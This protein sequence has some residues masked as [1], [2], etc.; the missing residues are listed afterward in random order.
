MEMLDREEETYVLVEYAFEYTAKDGRLVSIKPN[1]RYVLLRRTNDHWWHVRKGKGTRPFYIPAK[2][3]KELAPMAQAMPPSAEL[4]PTSMPK[5]ARLGAS[6][7]QEQPLE[8]E[9]HFVN[10]I[11]EC[12]GPKVD[13]GDPGSTS[14]L[15][16][17]SSGV[18]TVISIDIREKALLPVSATI[19]SSPSTLS[20]SH[21]SLKPHCTTGPDHFPASFGHSAEHIRPTV[22]LDDLARFAAHSQ[23]GVRNSGL[24][25]AASWGHPHQLMKS[26]SENFHKPEEDE[27]KWEAQKPCARQVSYL[28]LIIGGTGISK[29]S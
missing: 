4:P 5:N 9:Y 29:S 21:G 13:A 23:A 19:R 8:Y 1:E 24:Y 14:Q 15:P 7:E 12:K 26:S 10:A 25:K 27:E 28:F 2:Y 18:G 11:Q 6:T 17:I 20:A 16:S 3:V 22:S